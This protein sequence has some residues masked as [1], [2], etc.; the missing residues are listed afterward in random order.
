MGVTLER[1]PDEE[2]IETRLT[3][4]NIS[5]APLER[6]PDEEGIETPLLHDPLKNET[7]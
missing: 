7:G 5:N 3:A 4:S 6:G 1:G 2:G